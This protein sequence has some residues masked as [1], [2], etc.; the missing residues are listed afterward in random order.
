MESMF[1]IA[2]LITTFNRVD[3]LNSTLNALENQIVSTKIG[4]DIFLL[5]DGCSDNTPVIIN[6]NF[7]KVNI[8]SGNG[9]LFWNRGM[10]FLWEYAEKYRE[11]QFFLWLNDDTKLYPHAL[12]E[13]LD[14]VNQF[15]AN[16]IIVGNICGSSEN[17]RVTYGGYRDRVLLQPI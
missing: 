2:V 12:E 17:S 7:P 5:D 13:L 9:E 15:G 3:V 16:T 6:S 11:Y 10:L 14:G 1:R 8:V 4:F